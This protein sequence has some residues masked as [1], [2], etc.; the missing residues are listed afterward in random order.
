MRVLTTYVVVQKSTYVTTLD[1]TGEQNRKIGP[2]WWNRTEQDQ[3]EGTGG[4]RTGPD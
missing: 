3:T 1:Q 4:D 2:D